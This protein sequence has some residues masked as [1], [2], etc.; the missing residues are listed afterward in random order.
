MCLILCGS[1]TISSQIP[2]MCDPIAEVE[3]GILG[4]LQLPEGKA[5]VAQ[6]AKTAEEVKFVCS[7]DEMVSFGVDQV[8]SAHDGLLKWMNNLTVE[9][10]VHVLK[11]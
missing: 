2:V 11:I 1:Q 7:V 8:P 3:G 10:V 4:L 6:L 9:G 5:A